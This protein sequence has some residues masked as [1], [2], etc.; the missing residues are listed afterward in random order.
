MTKLTKKF[1]MAYVFMQIVN[2]IT[3]I[4][5]LTSAAERRHCNKTSNEATEPPTQMAAY[6]RSTPPAAPDSLCKR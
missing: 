4:H 3:K 5:K 1:T 2:K 6:K